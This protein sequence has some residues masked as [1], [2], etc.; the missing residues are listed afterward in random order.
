MRATR[1]NRKFVFIAGLHRSGTTLLADL[2]GAHPDI[3]A[4]KNTGAYM[5]E[6][7]HLQ[8]VYPVGHVWGGDAVGRFG[9]DPFAY[10]T[11]KSPLAAP[12]KADALFAQWARHWD[13]SRPVLLEK[14]PPNIIRTRYLQAC[15]PDS[16]FIVITRHPVANALATK[17]WCRRNPL[18]GIMTNWALCHSRLLRD[19]AY[20]KNCLIVR[21]EDMAADVAAVLRRATDFIGLP[22]FEPP[23]GAIRPDV[24]EKYFARWRDMC[25]SP[26]GR[27]EATL[28]R[29]MLEGVFRRF[30]YSFDDAAPPGGPTD[31]PRGA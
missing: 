14:S 24:N 8:S 10:L 17:K 22:P 27:A 2:L 15:F 1:F 23:P 28:G 18:I 21:Y 31:R 11:E 29:W 30:G 26:L 13:L 7:Q 25:T 4:F 20:L 12:D 9:F 16:Y 6:G 3:S 19:R 5:D